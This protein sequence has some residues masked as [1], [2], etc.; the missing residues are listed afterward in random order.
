MQHTQTHT[1]VP[2]YIRLSWVALWWGTAFVSL[3]GWGDI[4][5]ALLAQG[6]VSDPQWAAALIVGAIVVARIRRVV[7]VAAAL[8]RRAVVVVAG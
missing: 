6:G 4:S 7:I 1:P 2:M 5:H 8:I 3:M